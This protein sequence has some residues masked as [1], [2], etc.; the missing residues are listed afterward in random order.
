MY[1]IDTRRLV[2]RATLGSNALDPTVPD[3]PSR[4]LRGRKALA[5][6]LREW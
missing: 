2:N 4:R 6:I 5:A 3:R 1:P